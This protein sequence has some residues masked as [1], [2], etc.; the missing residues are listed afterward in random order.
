MCVCCTCA[1]I[2]HMPDTACFEATH[3]ESERDCVVPSSSSPMVE[4][5]EGNYVDV[6][7]DDPYG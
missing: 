6:S 2:M 3:T 5:D 7:E 4:E 1:C